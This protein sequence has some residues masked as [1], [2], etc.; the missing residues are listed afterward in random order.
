MRAFQRF[1]RGSLGHRVRAG[2]TLIELMVVIVI[3]ALLVALLTPAVM[4]VT[5]KARDAQVIKDISDL[6]QA[7]TQFKLVY[8]I[9]PPSS[10]TLYAKPPNATMNAP[11]WDNDPADPVGAKRSKGVIRQLWPKFNFAN[12]GG[13][14]NGTIFTHPAGL[15][16]ISLSGS[17]CLV[18]FLGGVID[19][20]TG[21]FSGFSK[22]PTR[23][24]IDPVTVTNREGPLFEFKG[25]LK[26]LS[27]QPP[28]G[29][30]THWSGRMTDK[31]GDWFPEYKDPLPSQT[32]PY[33][34][35]NGSS[36]Y[37]TDSSTTSPWHNTDNYSFP[38]GSMP[39]ILVPTDMAM[40]YA[41]YS[42][43]DSSAPPTMSAP[44]K[45]GGLQIIS[46]GADAA[47]GTGGDFTP[48]ST[49]C[50]STPARAFERDN[51]TN[52]HSGRLGG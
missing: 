45:K 22:D 44:H 3:I 49:S 40:P 37:Q 11:N 47:Y 41:Y 27:S 34:Y 15:D 25:A 7:I 19:P 29:N 23:P 24:F 17:E 13:S 20:N 26:T 12:C 14:S 9:D 52:F 43:F 4:S 18:F 8:G 6:E 36:S 32:N 35:F 46:P 16:K 38:N 1:H 10:I 5:K 28:V 48:G 21:A 31:D 42:K 2:F 51:L 30:D 33:V 50:F 39:P